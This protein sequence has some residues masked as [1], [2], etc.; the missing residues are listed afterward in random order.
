MLAFID[1]YPLYRLTSRALTPFLPLWLHYRKRK[2][3]KEN[4]ISIKARQGYYDVSRPSQP[5]VWVH[6]TSNG[7]VRSALPLIKKIHKQYPELSILLTCTTLSAHASL[8]AQLPSTVQFQFVPWDC[9]SWV[10]RFFDHWRPDLVMIVEQELW[11]NLLETAGKRNLPIILIN[12]R[13]SERSYYKW[14]V[15]RKTARRLFNNI[16]KCYTQD[17]CYDAFFRHLGVHEVSCLGDLKRQPTKLPFN[18]QD[19]TKIRKHIGDRPV[20][21]AASTHAG[22]E[23][24][25][26]NVTKRLRQDYPNLL[27]LIAPRH[28]KRMDEI[29][30]LFNQ[31]GLAFQT[32]SHDHVPNA[33]INYFIID[34]FGELGLFFALAKFCFMGGSLVPTKK[35]GGHNPMEAAMFRLPILMGPDQENCRKTTHLLKINQ[36]LTEVSNEDALYEQAKTLLDKPELRDWIA[37]ALDKLING[38]PSPADDLTQ[39]LK[40]ILEATRTRF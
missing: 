28:P 16:T 19:Y 5:L 15:F 31:Q 30:S 2:H 8:Q 1:F 6:A 22:E 36:I 24:I 26:L 3:D 9:P 21:I 39:A 7:E 25:I 18:P 40:P 10:E 38:L 13:L 4:A 37:S 20:W 34:S 11:P 29:K 12:S 35:I 14:R 27:T 32:R 33:N 17:E 23:E